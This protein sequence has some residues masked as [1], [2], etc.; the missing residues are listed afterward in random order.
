MSDVTVQSPSTKQVTDAVRTALRGYRGRYPTLLGMIRVRNPKTKITRRWLQ[1][2]S[3]GKDR[4]PRFSK[5]VEL[6]SALGVAIDI[7]V[8][9]EEP[10]LPETRS[11]G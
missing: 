3:D 9:K 8:H 10:L 7:V 4:E 6:G 11:H 1:A 5:V 2:F